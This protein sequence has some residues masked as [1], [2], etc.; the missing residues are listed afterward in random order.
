MAEKVSKR[1]AVIR[2]L[3]KLG[4][5]AMPKESSGRGK[6]PGNNRTG[7]VRKRP[8]ALGRRLRRPPP[9]REGEGG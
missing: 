8:P 2:S 1:D 7:K 5:E 9:G 3:K 4:K 6:G